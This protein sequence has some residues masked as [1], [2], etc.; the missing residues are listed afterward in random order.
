LGPWGSLFRRAVKEVSKQTVGKRVKNDM[1]YSENLLKSDF[2]LD[3]KDLV[4]K[5]SH[6]AASWIKGLIEQSSAPGHLQS[7]VKY[8]G[9]ATRTA[10]LSK[11]EKGQLWGMAKGKLQQMEDREL[12][13]KMASFLREHGE[14]LLP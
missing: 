6:V 10:N 5:D 1:E 8:L 3:L 12:L 9:D 2:K 11:Q 14:D 13:R 7:V 4:E